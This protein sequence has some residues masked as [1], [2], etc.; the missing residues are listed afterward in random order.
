MRL[1][2]NCQTLVWEG[3]YN[4]MSGDYWHEQCAP[5][6]LIQELNQMTEE[7]LDES[8]VYYSEWELK[9]E[10]GHL[11]D[12]IAQHVSSLSDEYNTNTY[13]KELK[14]STVVFK[15]TATGHPMYIVEV[16][17]TDTH[18]I[19]TSDGEELDCVEH[20]DLNI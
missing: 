8:G 5:A 15:V 12:E 6:S 20:K 7:E 3:Y 19:I 1:C 14:D 11:F 18:F 16:T 2:S 9:E 17:I 13:F 4:E 10:E